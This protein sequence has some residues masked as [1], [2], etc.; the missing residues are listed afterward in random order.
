MRALHG[1][2]AALA[3]A[4]MVGCALDTSGVEHAA[5]LYQAGKY[6]QA[7][8]A[9]REA[10]QERGVTPEIAYDLGVT[11]YRLRRYELAAVRFQQ[12]VD[13]PPE[14]RQSSYYDLG[15]ALVR[16]AQDTSDKRGPLRHAI[17]AYQE[18]LLQS[19]GDSAAKWNLEVALRR[20]AAQEEAGGGGGP[21][22]RGNWGR[23][24]MTKAGYAGAPEVATGATA[25]GGF[26]AGEGESVREMSPS[27]ARE[28][29]EG[30]RRDEL[31]T[32]GG[33]NVPHR[34]GATGY[35]DW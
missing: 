6:A 3:L 21:R 23:G 31:K 4:T 22:Q 9:L 8:D 34:P 16:A 5:H 27:D 20:L 1:V 28:I 33:R 12:A 18:A 2:G 7:Y 14:L 10:A 35:E 24:N 25:G 30:A 13:G 17:Q 26:G 19:P 32:H 11:L 15:N 29:V